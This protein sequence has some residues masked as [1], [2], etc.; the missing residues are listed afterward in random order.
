MIRSRITLPFWAAALFI[1]L[2]TGCSPA[3]KTASPEADSPSSGTA[4]QTTGEKEA[5]PRTI[6]HAKGSLEIGKKPEKVA[7]PY[8]VYLDY[9]TVLDEP[10]HASQGMDMI[11]SFP[12]LKK[13]LEGKQVLDLGREASMEKLLAAS[14][15]LIISEDENKFTEYNKIA[16]TVIIPHSED[17]KA[18]LRII[19]KVIG[20]EEK[21]ESVI[22]DY[23]KKAAEYKEKLASKRGE[24]VLAAMFSGKEF[25]SF[26]MSR[27]RVF[28]EDLG[29]TPVEAF[30][31]GGNFN[32]EGLAEADP[33]YLFV[34]NNYVQPV[35]GGVMASMKDNPIW[36]RLKAVKNNH[37]FVLDDSSVI[38]PMPLGK[39]V[40]IDE[41]MKAMSGQ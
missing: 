24:T 15:D 39:I 25:T 3:E 10:P 12:N 11:G 37:V 31:Q 9:L 32:L 7:T 21:A 26:N 35:A 4:A 17:W 20:A 18:Q 38:G 22:A 5:F 30:K 33:D 27:M 16:P 8:I 6:Q 19:A 23:E 2:L 34:V 13:R 1:L 14:P 29:L 36:N 40:A 41:I 28:Y